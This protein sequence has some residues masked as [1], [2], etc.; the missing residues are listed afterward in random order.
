MLLLCCCDGYCTALSTAVLRWRRLWCAAVVNKGSVFTLQRTM[1]PHGQQLT[2][3][4]AVLFFV[5]GAA[6]LVPGTHSTRRLTIVFCIFPRCSLVKLTLG[7]RYLF[8]VRRGLRW[9]VLIVAAAVTTL[10]LS[11]REDGEG[12]CETCDAASRRSEETTC[13]EM[14]ARSTLSVSPGGQSVGS[15]SCSVVWRRS[16]L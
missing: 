9:C 6:G 1:Q 4:T 3:W 5:A 2:S 8:V 15:R 11:C 7:V 10:V 13:E 14:F 12:C 16:S